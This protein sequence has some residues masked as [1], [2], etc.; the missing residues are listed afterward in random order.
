[1][2]GASKST[3]P[4]RRRARKAACASELRLPGPIRASAEC[5]FIPQYGRLFHVYYIRSSSLQQLR[6]TC[7]TSI[8]TLLGASTQAPRQVRALPLETRVRHRTAAIRVSAGVSGRNIC[9]SPRQRAQLFQCLATLSNNQPSGRGE[10]VAGLVT[11]KRFGV[12]PARTVGMSA[13]GT[14]AIFIRAD[15][16]KVGHMARIPTSRCSGPPPRHPRDS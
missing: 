8:P 13:T 7:P 1:M 16:R 14:A 3:G 15:R 2:G 9:A 6:A 12:Y 5:K 10:W 4:C 11:G